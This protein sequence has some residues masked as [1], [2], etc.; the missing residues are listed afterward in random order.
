MG[1]G[2]M[3]KVCLHDFHNLFYS[4]KLY[5]TSNVNFEVTVFWFVLLMRVAKTCL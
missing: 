5:Q 2:S 3:Q 1:F 4:N